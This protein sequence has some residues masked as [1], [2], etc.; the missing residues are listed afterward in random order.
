M[1]RSNHYDNVA[2]HHD[3]LIKTVT[4]NSPMADGPSETASRIGEISAAVAGLDKSTDKPSSLHTT[5]PCWA[6]DIWQIKCLHSPDVLRQS[7]VDYKG[8]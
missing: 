8:G 7:A 6:A 4:F 2:P 1:K 3:V 5:E